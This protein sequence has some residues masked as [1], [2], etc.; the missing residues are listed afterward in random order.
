MAKK[1]KVDAEQTRIEILNAARRVF[2]KFGV[3][4]SSLEQVA[5]V[6]GVTRG[7]IYWHF[8]NKAE[9]FYKLRESVFNQI[10]SRVDMPL[11]AAESGNSLD[12]IEIS[13]CEFFKIIEESVEV[14][15]VFEIMTYRCELVD[16]FSCIQEEVER[17]AQIFLAKIDFVYQI[18]ERKGELRKGILASA[19]A[20][21][22]WA[23][24]SGL[25]HLYLGHQSEPKR[26]FDLR[27]MISAHIQLRRPLFD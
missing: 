8:K 7:A 25:L 12:A 5:E 4:C 16:E 19:A 2:H 24:T 6:A 10:Y 13:L 15:E 21:D 1:T 20:R 18:A 27:S 26:P 23:F 11:H 17:P 14:R 22:T 9:L 3:N